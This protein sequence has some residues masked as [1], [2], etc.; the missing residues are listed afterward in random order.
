MSSN[1]VVVVVWEVESTSQQNQYVPYS[2][3]VSQHLER[4]YAKHLTQVFLG[5]SDT[6]LNEYYVNLRTMKQCTDS[7]A[8]EQL[9]VRRQF[10]SPQ[11]P[12]GKG[13]KWE[14]SG[15][16]KNQWILF[17][18][19]VQCLIEDAWS[20]GNNQIDLST[21]YSHLP[22]V[23]DFCSMI[24]IKK[25][26]GPIKA[27]RRTTQ[28]MYPLTKLQNY[29]TQS[30][31]P[32]PAK[33]P[34]TL[35]S[36]RFNTSTQRRQMIVQHKQL[37][38]STP[39]LSNSMEILSPKMEFR[40]PPPVPLSSY[41][42]ASTLPA[43]Q[44]SKKSTKKSAESNISRLLNNLNIFSHHHH[45][46]MSDSNKVGH[47][48]AKSTSDNTK[49]NRRSF[50][51]SSQ[52]SASMT[53]LESSSFNSRRPSVDTI[54][55]YLSS[56]S[57]KIHPHDERHYRGKFSYESVP[58]LLNLSSESDDVFMPI[59]SGS[60]MSRRSRCSMKGSIVG[61]DSSS[62]HLSRFVSVV[63]A[64]EIQKMQTC[65][66]CLN[67]LLR[68]NS[69]QNPSV[70]LSRCKHLMHL[71]CLNEL[72]LNQRTG[73]QKVNREMKETR[74]K[75]MKIFYDLFFFLQQSFYIECPI[76]SSVYGEKY[77]NQPQGT[78]SWI[79]IPKSLPGHENCNTIQIIY[80]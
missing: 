24:Q 40:K 31:P 10:Y 36:A 61:I 59:T 75:N 50:F 21:S 17:D 18:I 5:D 66:I 52:G 54:S 45:D 57:G 74:E 29:M 20:N 51:R 70:S 22:Y 34:I 64:N 55:T 77:G 8:S 2:P 28:A 27:I 49:L 25:P 58:D 16:L 42:H 71:I 53:D 26:S 15:N 63:E 13:I 43:G 23:I 39:K 69:V 11:S 60:R 76:C 6:N 19:E 67:E 12:L 72:I 14:H 9:D 37:S 46:K 41:S 68:D 32:P 73:I 80:K 62:E 44:S 7:N 33:M 4:A 35:N 1:S 79:T 48:S 78:M 30:K 47:S 56:G 3:S 38:T 65:P